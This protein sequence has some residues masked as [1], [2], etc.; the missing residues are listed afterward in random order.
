MV[1]EW[2]VILW[3]DVESWLLQLDERTYIRVAA[4]IDLLALEGPRLGRP[5]V[6]RLHGSRHHHMKELRPRSD[7]QSAIRML[8]AFDPS[9]RAVILFAGDKAGRWN[10]WYDDAI[11][12]ADDRFDAWLAE[13]EGTGHGKS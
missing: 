8:F 5:V 11:S 6:D 10:R 13:G 7:G 4:A 9:R 2:E 1:S 3:E 12:I